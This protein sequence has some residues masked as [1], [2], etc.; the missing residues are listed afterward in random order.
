[1]GRYRAV[2]LAL[3]AIVVVLSVHAVMAQRERRDVPP[4]ARA[5]AM[6]AKAE[7]LERAGR[8][9][10]A[11]RVRREAEELVARNRKRREHP[12]ETPLAERIGRAKHQ[13]QVLMKMAHMA[14]EADMPDLAHGLREQAEERERGLREAI[15]RRERRPEPEREH[16]LARAEQLRREAGEMKER[17]RAERARE[18][19]EEAERLEAEAREMGGP[20]ELPPFAHELF[21]QQ[22]KLRAEVGELR[23]QLHGLRQ[24]LADLKAG[25]K[26]ARR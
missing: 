8:H 26:K 19:W 2:L 21:R 10:D 11:D 3:L 4:E 24:A 18:L 15:E 17:G 5:A 25:L 12:E 20:P 7:A 14:A 23:E 22:E 16:L 1:M 6:H 13:I 9:E